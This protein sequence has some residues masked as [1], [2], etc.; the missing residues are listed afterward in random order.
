MKMVKHY[1]NKLSLNHR[2]N[3]Q[4]SRLYVVSLMKKNEYNKFDEEVESPKL[5]SYVLHYPPDVELIPR[6]KYKVQES[7]DKDPSN[8]L[9]REE[10]MIYAW[11][12]KEAA[13]DEESLLKQKKVEWLK[14]GDSNSA[15]FH[16]VI[17]GRV[18]RNRIEVVYDGSGKAYYGDN[19]ADQFVSHFSS[20]LDTCDDLLDIEDVDNLFTKKLDVESSVDLIK[21][22][23]DEEIKKALF[24]IDVNK[25][26]GPDGAKRGLRQGNPISPYL[27]TLGMKV[28]NLMIKRRIRNKKR[29]KYHSGCQK[30]KISR[31]YF[32]D[33]LLMLC[34][35]DMVSDSILR[36]GLDEFSMSSDIN[37]KVIDHIDNNTWRWP[38]EWVGEYDSVLNVM[39]PILSDDLEDKAV[40]FKKGKEKEFSLAVKERL[41]TRDRLAKCFSIND[42]SCLL[43]GLNDESQSHLFFSCLYFRRL[44]E[45]LKPMALLEIVSNNWPSAISVLAGPWMANNDLDNCHLF[46]SLCT[47]RGEFLKE[48]SAYD[49]YI[50]ESDGFDSL[51]HI[52]LWFPMKWCTGH[53]FSLVVQVNFGKCRDYKVG[54]VYA[55]RGFKETNLS[56]MLLWHFLL[57]VSLMDEE[58][59]GWLISR[60]RC[61]RVF[62]DHILF[63]AGLKPS[64]EHGQQRPAIKVGGKE[65]AFRNFIYTKDDDDLAFLP[66]DPSSRFDIGSPSASVNMEPPK[67][68]DEPKV[69]LAKVTTYSVESLRVDVFVVHLGSVAACIKERKFNMRAREF[70]QVIQKMSGEANNPAV[71]ALQEKIS[72]LTADVKEHKEADKARLEAVEASLRIEVEELKQDR[73]DVVSKA[74]ER[75]REEECE[76]LR[77]KCEAA[78]A[79][80]DQNPAVLALQE[81]ISSLTADVKEDKGNL[82]RMMLES[83]KWVGYQV[84]L[85]TLKPKVNSLEADKAGLEDVEAS[86]RREAEELKQDRR[87]VVSKKDHTQ[88]SND[89]ATA[90]FLWLDEFV[91]YA[92]APIE[93]MLSKKPS[94]LQKPAPSRT[95]MHVPS[96]QKATPFAAPSSNMMSPPTNHVKPSLSLLR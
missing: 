52:L 30:L 65:I 31:L 95:Q 69:Q 61:V 79:E 86:L 73:R 76:G 81:K 24:S 17:K 7:L 33:D 39:V 41:K 75:S 87:D 85:S 64:W 63:L 67:D 43:C 51:F 27:F 6:P 66:K 22:I 16:N 72:S 62:P 19:V 83:R 11:A 14:E 34:Y 50:V 71:L 45:R 96:S 56:N 18:S 54:S 90:T 9:L 88:S 28:L 92:T 78:M 21:P 35:G 36:I 38:M 49:Y 53:L 91:A 82:D 3:L 47:S 23:T 4:F 68:V 8:S 93:T 29:F 37:A 10:E 15:Y 42:K 84:T 80:F 32:A 40:W 44:W 12:Y 59:F 25:A 55:P 70:L 94:M 46:D 77:V 89:F 58:S 2:L 20:F 57:S 48:W 26:S 60:F 13:I 1:I 74:R 5:V